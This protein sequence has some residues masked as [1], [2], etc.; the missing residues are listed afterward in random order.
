[1]NILIASTNQ[2]K[3]LSLEQ[4][5]CAT[6]ISREELSDEQSSL[7]VGGHGSGGPIGYAAA[8]HGGGGPI[9]HAVEEHGGGGPI[10]LQ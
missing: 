6:G 8:E 9:G 4:V 7:V 10:G 5:L 3:N 2:A 1:M